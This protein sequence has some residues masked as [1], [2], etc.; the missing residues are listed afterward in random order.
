MGAVP[1]S[2]GVG[3]TV[4]CAG[5]EVWCQVRCGFGLAG[6]AWSGLF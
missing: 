2:D 1:L 3:A 4:G 5:C 6:E